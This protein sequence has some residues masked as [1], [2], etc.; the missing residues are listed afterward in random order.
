M[1]S[2]DNAVGTYTDAAKS[3]IQHMLGID[4][5]LAPNETDPFTS[6]H[7]IGDLFT[8]GGVLYRA[9]TAITVADALNIGTNAEVISVADIAIK[10]VQVN[11]TSVLS[12][13]VAN[14][15]MASTT[16]FGVIKVGSGLNVYNNK[17]YTSKAPSS[18][19]KAGTGENMVIVPYNQHESTFYGLAKAAGDSTQSQSNNAVG[20]YTDDAK[21]AIQTMLGIPTMSDIISAVH[22][23][24]AVAE[25]VSF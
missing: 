20:T 25:E 21:A 22:S 9:K 17:L 12:N 5:V 3:A 11:G 6:A 18:T 7:A 8:I 2:S 24:Y 15:P 19:V 1:S 23:S 10:D 14:V 13:G 4:S 16:E